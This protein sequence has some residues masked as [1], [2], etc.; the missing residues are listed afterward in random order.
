MSPLGGVG[1]RP[2]EVANPKG[3]HERCST[4]RRLCR[5]EAPA[6]IANW[7]RG[8]CFIG[9]DRFFPC[10]MTADAPLGET[11]RPHSQTYAL[12]PFEVSVLAAGMLV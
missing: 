7:E 5:L 6:V 4:C 2:V 1:F 12:I 9:N 8:N 11:P 3:G 10:P